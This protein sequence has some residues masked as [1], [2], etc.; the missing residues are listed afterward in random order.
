MHGNE[1]LGM[2]GLMKFVW[3]IQKTYYNKTDVFMMLNNVRVLVIPVLNMSGF[4]HETKHETR[5]V[6]NKDQNIDPN[7]DF[8]LNPKGDCF[9]SLSSQFLLKIYKKYLIF[10][11]LSFTKGDFQ[12]FYPQMAVTLGVRNIYN[13]ENFLARVANDLGTVFITNQNV[14][15]D[16]LFDDD[17]EGIPTLLVKGIIPKKGDGSHLLGQTTQGS[18][19]DWAFGASEEKSIVRSNCLPPKSEL[20]VEEIVPSEESNRAISI[21]IALDKDRISQEDRLMGNEIACVDATAPGAE[22]GMI[23]GIVVMVNRFIQ[24]LSNNVSLDTVKVTWEPEREDPDTLVQVVEFT[25]KIFSGA[26]ISYAELKN[27]KPDSQESEF[28]Y[29]EGDSM[30]DKRLHIKALFKGDHMLKE[31]QVYDLKFNLDLSKYFLKSVEKSPI[32]SSHYLKTKLDAQYPD[33]LKKYRLQIFDC[34]IYT[35]KNMQIDR[36]DKS[37]IYERFSSYSRFFASKNLLVQVGSYFP[38]ELQ[39]DNASGE[40]G[41]SVLTKNIPQPTSEK[42][43]KEGLLYQ[44]GL[45]N[46]QSSA[47]ESQVLQKRLSLFKGDT[48]DIKAYI[49]NQELAYMCLNLR[50]E[51]FLNMVQKGEED[52]SQEESEQDLVQPK[53]TESFGKSLETEEKPLLYEGLYERCRE[54]L[55]VDQ[56]EGSRKYMY[57]EFNPE[58]PVRVIPSVFL[59][60]IGRKIRF[61]VSAPTNQKLLDNGTRD[62][63]TSVVM[64]SIIIS[65]PMITGDPDSSEMATIPSSGEIIKMPHKNLLPISN[66]KLTCGSFTPSL[67]VDAELL[68]EA[69]VEQYNL[70]EGDDPDFFYISVQNIQEETDKI[71]ISMFTNSEKSPKEYVLRNKDQTFVLKKMENKSMTIVDE[72]DSQHRLSVYRSYFSRKK[73]G[74]DSLLLMVYEK[75]AASP[76][77]DCFLKNSNGKG[78]VDATTMFK[79]YVGLLNEIEDIVIEKFGE[80]TNTSDQSSKKVFI[81]LL[82]MCI[83]I[84]LT[85][86]GGYLY[87]M[88]VNKK[89]EV[90]EAKDGPSGVIDKKEDND[91]RV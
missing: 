43:T 76:V 58:K 9:K 79:I 46:S 87:H 21:E 6:N 35:I 63:S 91:Q 48:P 80:E 29:G 16:N 26:Y 73:S 30:V 24:K 7:F 47:S 5:K 81:I 1:T 40:L 37:L 69:A 74:I 25:F 59:N 49:Y 71:Q 22:F 34:N 19:I 72:E 31:D 68:E 18:Y 84:C 61:E 56:E 12:I 82:F 67:P 8:N 11:T 23:P 44:I 60:L 36:F 4:Y 52:M 75:E 86:G 85:A 77:F 57:M 54:F 89:E 28:Y 90:G 78:V 41:Y 38:F 10:G 83:V 55:E 66:F 2:L 33:T 17:T 51:G 42:L 70:K 3:S 50:T 62:K 14:T 53:T 20:K 13:D 32:V 45:V 88:E 65:D 64:G 27:P 39:Y 15:L